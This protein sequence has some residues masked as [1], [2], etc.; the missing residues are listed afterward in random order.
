MFFPVLVIV[1]GIVWLLNNLGIISTGV[2]SIILPVAVILAGV[3]MIS[4]KNCSWCNLHHDQKD[5][6]K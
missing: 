3:S 6:P 5:Q 4:K 2:W 1:V